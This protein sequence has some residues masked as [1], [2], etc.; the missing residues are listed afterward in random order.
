M[1]CTN[2]IFNIAEKEGKGCVPSGRERITSFVY[3][4]MFVRVI[5]RL[6]ISKKS[7]HC[8]IR[9]YLDLQILLAVSFHANVHIKQS[10][11]NA[12]NND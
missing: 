6:E 10:K 9:F 11:C 1:Y 4:C 5:S 12:A 7:T 3:L 8:I 2:K